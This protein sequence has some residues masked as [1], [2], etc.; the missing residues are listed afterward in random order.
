MRKI[1]GYKKAQLLKCVLIYT[2]HE[3]SLEELVQAKRAI[4]KQIRYFNRKL[5]KR[6]YE[7]YYYIVGIDT[8]INELNFIDNYLSSTI[9]YIRFEDLE[10]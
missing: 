8:L 10:L 2:D 6:G 1:N 7:S 9:G 4:E 5:Y 3:A